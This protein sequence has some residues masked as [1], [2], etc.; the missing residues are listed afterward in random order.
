LHNKPIG[1]GASG[2]YVPGPDEEEE[3][4]RCVSCLRIQN[5]MLV[6]DVQLL[7]VEYTLKISCNCNEVCCI[8]NRLINV[9]INGWWLRIEYS[10]SQSVAV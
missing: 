4:E 2:A 9:L 7:S 3:E 8:E 1:C 6:L 10:C 5:W